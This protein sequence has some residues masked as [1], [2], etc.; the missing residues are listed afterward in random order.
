MTL[1]IALLLAQ[2]H[3]HPCMQD[4]EKLCKG[5]T[6]GG[7]RIAAC[8]KSHK[9]EVSS[10]CS[11]RM[12]EFREEAQSC[13]AD[14]QKLC[15]GTRP[16]PERHQCMMEHKDQVSAE[17]KEFFAHMQEAHGEIRACREDAHKLCKDVKPGEGRI[18]DCLKS[19]QADLSK[20]C[21]AAIAH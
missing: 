13:E 9:S 8:L 18:V 11:S 15:P 19:H 2:A 3:T 5:I 7:G 12:A 16:G 17:C 21:A 4:A 1:V 20:T 14:V 10:E 6:P